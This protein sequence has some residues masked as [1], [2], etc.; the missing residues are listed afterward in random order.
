MAKTN[1]FCAPRGSRTPNPQIRSLML[2]P[3]EL[4]VRQVKSKREMKIE[5]VDVRFLVTDQPVVRQKGVEPPTLSS[6]G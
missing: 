6:V 2:Y 4:W 3:I 5:C 1:C